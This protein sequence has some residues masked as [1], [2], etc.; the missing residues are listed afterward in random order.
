MMKIFLILSGIAATLFF[1]VFAT[2]AKAARAHEDRLRILSESIHGNELQA[3][4]EQC[5]ALLGE[6]MYEIKKC[7]DQCRSRYG[8]P[9]MFA[10]CETYEP[11]CT[12]PGD[13]DEDGQNDRDQD[14][15]P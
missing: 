13:G 9:R 3:C 2:T 4:I 10:S 7:V 8:K 5:Q 12:R 1:S 15:R 11:G 6:P 14:G